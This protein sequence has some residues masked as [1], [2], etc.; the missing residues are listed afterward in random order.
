MA[1]TRH[2]DPVSSE[3][4]QLEDPWLRYR[5]QN[6]QGQSLKTTP[7]RAATAHLLHAVLHSGLQARSPA[8]QEAL[9][10]QQRP[11]GPPQPT[12]QPCDRWHDSTFLSVQLHVV[13]CTRAP[14][15]VRVSNFVF[16]LLCLLLVLNTLK[17]PTFQAALFMKDATTVPTLLEGRCAA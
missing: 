4:L 15:D 14:S 10:Q 2:R 3:A 9:V 12:V 17:N 11:R 8:P 13:A 6:Q 7:C 5:S 1:A 16:T